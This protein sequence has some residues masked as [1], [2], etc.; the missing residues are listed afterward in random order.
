MQ[1]QAFS[2]LDILRSPGILGLLAL[3]LG[4]ATLIEI[5]VGLVTGRRAWLPVAT[6]GLAGLLGVAGTVV[7][8]IAAHQ[9]IA[10]MGG[11]AGPRD[12]AEGIQRALCSTWLG[13]GVFAIGLVGTVLLVIVNRS[14]RSLREAETTGA[15]GSA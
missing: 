3:L 13:M 12:L 4:V 14:K 7:G 15:Q 5:P 8:M 11:A 2:A 6:G 10:V 1:P 9:K